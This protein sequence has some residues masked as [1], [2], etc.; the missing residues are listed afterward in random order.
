[1]ANRSSHG[2]GIADWWYEQD[3]RAKL[4]MLALVIVAVCVVAT[5]ILSLILRSARDGAAEPTETLSAEAVGSATPGDGPTDTPVP[6]WTPVATESESPLPTPRPTPALGSDPQGDVETYDDGSPVDDA[7]AGIDILSTN[8]GADMHVSL[9]PDG[10]TPAELAAWVEEDE[11]LM[12]LSLYDPIPLSP[13]YPM[14]WLV[15][16]DMDNDVESGRPVGAARINPDLGMEVAVGMF[17]N[18]ENKTYGTY[19]LIFDQLGV[20][21]GPEARMYID[22]SRTL[23]GLAVAL[24]PLIQAVEETV[25]VTVTLDSVIGRAAALHG[26]GE[27]RVIDFFP[28]RPD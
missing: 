21:A 6:T 28:E 15:V 5:L 11:M 12:W 25:G 26:A 4:L 7:P 22:D 16:L 24:D 8:V 27:D 20:T 3:Q 2:S 9:E 17:Y 13:T 23:V 10:N 1:M 19:T 14:E 18:P